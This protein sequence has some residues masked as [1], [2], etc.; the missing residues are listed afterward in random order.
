ME[1]LTRETLLNERK[2]Y[3]MVDTWNEKGKR[4]KRKGIIDE[5]IV[6]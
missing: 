3:V 5:M 2:Y 6:K 4:K 1:I